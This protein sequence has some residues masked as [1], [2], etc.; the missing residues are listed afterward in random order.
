MLMFVV[1]G[2]L[3]SQLPS[4]DYFADDT[5][6]ARIEDVREIIPD[7]DAKLDDLDGFV[8]AL[9]HTSFSGVVFVFFIISFVSKVILSRHLLAQIRP[10][11]PPL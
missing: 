4:K 6:R 10:R 11:S 1:C 3:L 7:G 2:M 5:Q 8:S 9:S